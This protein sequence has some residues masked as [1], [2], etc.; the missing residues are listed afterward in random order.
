MAF[1]RQF[2]GETWFM[3]LPTGE[4][5]HLSGTQLEAA[6]RCGLAGRGTPVRTV[7]SPVWTT[8]GEAAEI[9]DG[10]RDDVSSLAPISLQSSAPD[11][12]VGHDEDTQWLVRN[13]GAPE[14]LRPARSR[15]IF[16]L[17]AAA[18]ALALLVFVSTKIPASDIGRRAA[19]GT[20]SLE[21]SAPAAKVR[22][23]DHHATELLRTVRAPSERLSAEQRYRL[24]MRGPERSYGR[25]VV[26]TPINAP[27]PRPKHSRSAPGA[28]TRS[29]SSP[30][31]DSTNRFDPLNGAL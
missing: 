18:G 13:Y 22:S 29:S 16:G 26:G 7:S 31:V 11:L 6:F 23:L 15:P 8:L 5:E 21:A 17:V 10:P 20:Q 19:A 14:A 24:R 9:E 25:S 2:K 30:F 4:I 3:R 27:G 28:E 1:S 12:E